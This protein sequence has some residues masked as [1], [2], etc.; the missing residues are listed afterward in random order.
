MSD[1]NLFRLE[2]EVKP[3]EL[4]A[5]RLEKEIQALI[6]RNMETFFGVRFLAS[7]YT[8]AQTSGADVQGGRIDSL[9]IDENMC[10]VIFEYKRDVNENVINQG[11]FYLDW[12]IDH[13]ADFKLLVMEKLGTGE[14]EAIDWSSPTVYCIANA[15]GKYDLHAIKQ[16]NRNIRLIRYANGGDVLMFEYLNSPSTYGSTVCSASSTPAASGPKG[17]ADKTYAERYEGTTEALREIVD[18]VRRYM[19]SLGNDVSENVLKQ[20]LAIKKVRNVVCVEVNKTRVILH[21]RLDPDTVELSDIVMDARE[22]GHWGTGDLECSLH[23]MDELERVK[24]L[25]ERAY[26]EN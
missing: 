26:L 21:L 2:P 4:H 22:K 25:L 7:E 14:A 20:Y 19:G 12:L 16:M 10:P 5:V 13:Q 1:I 18:E 23:T 3:I 24:P 11:L 8:I 17:S 6:E 15:F 9:G